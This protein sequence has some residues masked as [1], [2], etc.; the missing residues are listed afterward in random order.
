MMMRQARGNMQ[1]SALTLLPSLLLI[2]NVGEVKLY[3]ESAR[4]NTVHL[5]ILSTPRQGSYPNTQ[6]VDGCSS[7][8][9]RLLQHSC[10][11]A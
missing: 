8:Y 5:L 9:Q 2:C 7:A 1:S 3:E 6:R 10:F 11:N 4:H